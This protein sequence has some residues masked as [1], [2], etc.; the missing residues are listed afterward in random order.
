MSAEWEIGPATAAAQLV[1]TLARADQGAGHASVRL[2]ATARPASIAAPHSDTPQST[3]ALAK[4][5]G[6]IADGVLTLHPQDAAGTLILQA[7]I[8][9]WAEWVAADGAVLARGRVTDMDHDGAFRIEGAAT[10][11][12]EDSP[13][14]FAGGLVQLGV[15]ALV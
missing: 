5:C 7:G 2:Y 10:P 14:F 13:L 9:R 8:P 11:E 12:G 4:P 15:T 6:A 3:I 1:A